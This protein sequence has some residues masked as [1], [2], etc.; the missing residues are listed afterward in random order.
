MVR[1]NYVYRRTEELFEYR[2]LPRLRIYICLLNI[3]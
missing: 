3:V 1:V 2:I